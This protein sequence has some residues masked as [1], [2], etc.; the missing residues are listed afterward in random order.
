MAEQWPFKP[1]V[2]SSSLSSLTHQIW[3]V[4]IVFT[5]LFVVLSGLH[6]TDKVVDVPLGLV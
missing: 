4:N 1:L 6:N 5:S 2:E 3:E